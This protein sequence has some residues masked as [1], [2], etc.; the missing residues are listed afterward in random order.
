LAEPAQR[1]RFER[2]MLP[3]LDA[4]Y[5]LALWLTRNEAQAADAVQEAYLRA[6]RFFG[7]FRGEHGRPWLLKIVRH[8]CYELRERDQAATD[9]VEFEEETMGAESAA[10]GAVF[11]LPVNPEAALIERADRELVQ[12]CLRAL[13]SDYREAL[14]LRELHGCSYKE[15]AAIAGIPIGTVM[16]RLARGRRLLQARICEQARRKDTGT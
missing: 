6:L 11:V 15:I 4:A 13:P 8:A 14:V 16:S 10:A 12:R 3:H 7:S 1:T 5:A 9:A 2:L